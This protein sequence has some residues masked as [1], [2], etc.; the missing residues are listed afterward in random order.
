MHRGIVVVAVSAIITAATFVIEA[1]T[2]LSPHASDIQLQLARLFFDEGR[3]VDSLDA[4]EKASG[5]DDP[6][7]VR[8]ARA[9]V[10]QS[11]L[12]VA[13]FSVARREA[14]KLVAVEPQSPDALS[15]YGYSLWASGLF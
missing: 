10:I 6:I 12:R 8:Q 2:R 3:Y 14:E 1:D 5:G 13:E 11:A 7:R 4:Y 9:G 15:L